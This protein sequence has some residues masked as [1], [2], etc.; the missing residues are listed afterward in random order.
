MKYK[1]VIE[2]VCDAYDEDDA[3]HIAGEY[4]RGNEEFGV[5]MTFNTHSMNPHNKAEAH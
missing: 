3:C 1:T 4:L 5:L 2:I